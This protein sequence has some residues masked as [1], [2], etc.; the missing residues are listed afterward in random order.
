MPEIEDIGSFDAIVVG[1]GMAG[2]MAANSLARRGHRTLLVEKHAVPGGCTTNFE[3]AD[4]RFEASNHV[5]NGC[6]PGGMTYRLL[7]QIGAEKRVEFIKLASFGR[8][9]DE[10]RGTEFSLPW[11][12][13]EHIEMLVAQ[14]PHEE[15]GLRR[16]YRKY[17]EM[18]K[19]LVGSLGTSPESHPEIFERLP[20]AGEDYAALEGL[21]AKDVLLEYVSDRHLVSTMLAI[22]SGFM[23]T[24]Y[25]V[26]D[27]GSAIMCDMIFRLD[28]GQAY[29]PKGGSGEMSRV[30]AD[31]FVENGGTLLLNRAVA[32]IQFQGGRAVGV[33]AK[34]RV[35]H[36]LSARGRCVVSASDLTTLVNRLCPDGTFPAEYVKA[37]NERVPSISSVILFAGLDI[38]LRARG[39]HDSEITRTWAASDVPSP[40]KRVART[41][42]FS[43]LPSA[44]ATIYSNIDPSCCPPGKSVVATMCLAEPEL[45][46]RSLGSGRQRGRAYK[47]L[48]Q[49]ITAELLAKMERALGIPDLESHAEV[50]EL[51][52]PITIERFTENRGGAYVGW[53]YSSDQARGHFPQQSPIE[54]L[55]LCGHW[56]SPGGG[57]SN[58]MSGGLAV[59]ELADA[60]LNG[61]DSA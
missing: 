51:A 38:D 52:T 49:R 48:K 40:F 45:F 43:K 56:V 33:L 4:Y 6:R 34:K 42:E 24:S 59:A 21:K 16:F 53:K 20:A 13:D 8:V 29:Y 41:C 54:N 25:D 37:V 17:G 31:L 32:E 1:A 26:L 2:L 30:L 39:I 15:K 61:E 44:M 60:Y 14:F 18:A 58:V 9:V 22:P 12:L 19:V 23:G 35:D 3:R 55:L 27:A 11:D 57:V 5:I 28:G 47:E 10:A 46:E 36:F 7:E 50:L